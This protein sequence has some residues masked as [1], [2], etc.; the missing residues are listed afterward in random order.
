[1]CLNHS[2][3]WEHRNLATGMY[4]WYQKLVSIKML[5]VCMLPKAGIHVSAYTP[6]VNS[7]FIE[8]LNTEGVFTFNV[9]QVLRTEI[10]LLACM[11]GIRSLSPSKCLMYACSQKQEYMSQHTPPASIAHSLK[12]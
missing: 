5:N 8:E 7:T 9:L 10:W 4:G 1:M 3:N 12:N 6:S 2:Q 11:A